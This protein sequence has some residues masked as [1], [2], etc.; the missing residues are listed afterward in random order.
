METLYLL[1]KIDHKTGNRVPCVVINELEV[2]RQWDEG[3]QNCA[4]MFGYDEIN[5]ESI[6][7]TS[8]AVHDLFERFVPEAWN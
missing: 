6:T 4:I 2:A 3:I 7:D 1:W 5:L 8:T